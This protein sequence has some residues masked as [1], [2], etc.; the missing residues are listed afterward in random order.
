MPPTDRSKWPDTSRNVTPTPSEITA[1]LLV[2]RLS[3]LSGWKKFGTRT[4]AMRKRPT[5]TDATS[6]AMNVSSLIRSWSSNSGRRRLVGFVT[7][8]L[9]GH[10]R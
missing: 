5:A 10:P 9:I 3:M 2:T 1:Q 7:A 6:T 4:E 8:P